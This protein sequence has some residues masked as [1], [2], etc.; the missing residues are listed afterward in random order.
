MTADWPQCA[1][2][3]RAQNSFSLLHPLL[4]PGSPDPRH[5]ELMFSD[6]INETV[7]DFSSGPRIGSDP[8]GDMKGLDATHFPTTGVFK[9]TLGSSLRSLPSKWVLG[10]HDTAVDCRKTAVW[11]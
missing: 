10:E 7:G 9:K 4:S 3:H 5:L 8:A 1:L 6:Q 11:K 2:L